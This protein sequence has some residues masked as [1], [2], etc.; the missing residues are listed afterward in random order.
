VINE[1]SLYLANAG[2]Y[3]SES[4]A[5]EDIAFDFCIL[6]KVLPKLHGNRQELEAPLAQLLFFSFG[7]ASPNDSTG[8]FDHFLP[9]YPPLFPSGEEEPLLPRFP[10]TAAKVYRMWS[11][12]RTRGFVSFVE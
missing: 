6:Q 1:M 8:A 11:T 4:P 9:G 7:Q 10:R 2:E 5:A 3:V 12:L